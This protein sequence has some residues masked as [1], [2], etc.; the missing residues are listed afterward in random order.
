MSAEDEK[1][2]I[3]ATLTYQ[4]MVQHQGEEYAELYAATPE[5]RLAYISWWA[6][7]FNT[8][9]DQIKDLGLEP[10]YFASLAEA[11]EF[12]R[13]MKELDEKEQREKGGDSSE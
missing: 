6:S 10:E 12:L 11:K 2:R 5:E 1:N 9:N 13:E 4:A 8:E 7:N 3:R